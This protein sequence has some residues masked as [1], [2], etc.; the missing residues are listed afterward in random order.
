MKGKE[1]FCPLATHFYAGLYAIRVTSGDRISNLCK[2]RLR[3]DTPKIQ[4]GEGA[5]AK[6]GNV[7]VDSILWSR[8]NL[9]Y[10]A[11]IALQPIP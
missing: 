10:I 8:S 1:Q 5:I 4:P 7:Q 2:F 11:L 6:I 3:E 9:F